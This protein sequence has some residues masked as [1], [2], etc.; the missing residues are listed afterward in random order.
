[1]AAFSFKWVLSYAVKTIIGCC[2]VGPISCTSK[3]G[4]TVSCNHVSVE[5]AGSQNLGK[6]H[7][8][9]INEVKGTGIKDMLNKRLSCR[10][11]WIST[12]KKFDEMLNLSDKLSWEDQK[13]LRLMEK[14]VTKEDGHY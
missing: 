13:F 12:S 4:D 9:V 10:F 2:V 3:N 8:S 6:H 5:K 14:E 1:M 7:F 11:H